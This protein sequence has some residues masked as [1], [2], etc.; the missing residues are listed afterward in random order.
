[1]PGTE[2]VASQLPQEEKSPQVEVESVIKEIFPQQPL[3]EKISGDVTEIPEEQREAGTKEEIPQKIK[4]KGIRKNNTRRNKIKAAK[5]KKSKKNEAGMKKKA[6]KNNKAANK[7]LIKVINDKKEVDSDFTSK[8]QEVEN[9]MND[10]Q[11]LNLKLVEEVVKNHGGRDA[12]GF[13]LKP[14]EEVAE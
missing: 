5:R 8:P 4:E 1:M 9:T 7:N 13:V 11:E 10:T 6:K 12:L 2:D 14:A 3:E